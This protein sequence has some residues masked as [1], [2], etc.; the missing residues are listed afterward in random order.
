MPGCHRDV[1]RQG[2]VRVRELRN[3]DELGKK[4]N[5]SMWEAEI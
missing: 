4:Q 2:C 3:S 5:N 1:L